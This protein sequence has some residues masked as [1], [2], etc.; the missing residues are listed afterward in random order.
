M[1]SLVG[2]VMGLTAGLAACSGG[3]PIGGDRLPVASIAVS[4][5]SASLVAGQSQRATA[6]AKD[7]KGNALSG[8]TITWRSSNSQIASVDASGMIAAAAPG[9]AVITASSEGVSG[10][11]TQG[12]T[13]SPPAPVAT[14]AVGPDGQSVQVGSTLQLSA[15]T[16]D[17]GGNTLTGRNIAWSSNN[18]GVA[19]VSSAGM[20]SGVAAGNATI[21]A[22]SEGKSGAASVIITA[23]PP[24]P[25]ATVAVTP[26]NPSVQVGA[27]TQ[28]TATTKD[29]N[30]AVLSGRVVSWSSSNTG[31]A[32]VSG[33]GVVTG[34]AAGNVTITATSEGKNG[35]ASVTVT[36][37]PPVPVAT[38]TV[39][40]S[41][42]SVQVGA[43]TQLSA[44]TKDAN[45]A[46]LSGRA[47]SW[48]SSNT[49]LA[50]VSGS[51][52]V[53][54]VAAGSV[55]ITATSEG[56][57]GTAS[58]T[59]TA[60]PP[61]PVAT[62]AV[63]PSN[64]SV[65]VG[66]TTQLS[67]TTKDANG[68]V[69]S[70]RVV[71]WSS[72][73]TGLAT[74]SGSGVVTGVAAGSVTITATSEGK[75]GTASVTIT[76]IPP[77]PVAT[78]AVSP[79]SATVNIGQTK[80][81][82][83]TLKDASGNVLTGRTVNWSSSNTAAA[84]V[85]ASG[86]VNAL[87]AGSATI[88][89]TSEGKSGTSAITVPTATVPPPTPLFTDD[90]ESGDLTKWDESNSTTQKVIR[91]AT[92]AHG[93]NYF[94]RMTYGI[95]GMDGAWLHKYFFNSGYS[96]MYVRYYIR[97]SDNFVGGTKLISLRGAPLGQPYQGVGRAG[98]CPTGRDSFSA[99]LVNDFATD[100][101]FPTKMYTY[102]QDMWA[103][104][105][106][107]CWGRYGATPS[108]LPYVSPMPPMAKGV[109]HKI[110]FTM[111]MNTGANIA[112]GEQRFWI[113]GV[114]YGEWKN[115]RWG[116]PAYVNLQVLQINGSG[117]TT[118][119]QWLDMDDLV[120]YEDYPSTSQP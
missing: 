29:A 9:S 63:T 20:V 65:Q 13:A 62:V 66:A 68:A 30:G 77:A 50:T 112:D 102:W 47:V 27:T 60:I 105:D 7:D 84:T 37:I 22:S 45:G 59:V 19:T 97:F 70:G 86:L 113:D 72:S 74:V 85:N 48:S 98:I 28:L 73:N 32:T 3:S 56:K 108:T 52:V 36:A 5:P 96:K 92:S 100:D 111:K 90:W 49:G 76:A 109:W 104:G 39:S 31:L 21:T 17:A 10:E 61:V 35:T 119:I 107:K 120:L 118:Q 81:L 71:S 18:T 14:V 41:A 43:T 53:T 89:A 33:S 94:L 46:V 82:T 117:N 114:K 91:D 110:E 64:P 2:A 34:V 25:V 83:V 115:I 80:Q 58:V 12:V 79:T 16:R 1:R 54:G 106:G 116:D 75:S 26:S 38:V 40:P 103:D 4:L 78:V 69:L 23:I 51:G 99:N 67:A 11:A 8:R 88:T 55:T 87:A 44:T 95:N 15:T 93:G 6:T 24:A 101:G 42:P 57:S